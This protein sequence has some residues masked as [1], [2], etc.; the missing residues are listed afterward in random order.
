MPCF[1]S[2]VSRIPVATVAAPPTANAMA[3][4]E[5]AHGIVS[6]ANGPPLAHSPL[7]TLLPAVA[8]AVPAEEGRGE[9]ATGKGIPAPGEKEDSPQSK[10]K[11]GA[12]KTCVVCSVLWRGRRRVREAPRKDLSPLS[13]PDQAPPPA[14]KG[15]KEGRPDQRPANGSGPT[16]CVKRQ[17]W[18]TES[19]P[20]LLFSD[21][22]K[23]I[24]QEE[25]N[26]VME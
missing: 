2:D 26:I 15:S 12:G 25:R 19:D 8:A 23:S 20:G 24:D 1:F 13:F 3:T 11:S 7:G 6:L 21:L 16:A 18:R 5:R 10:A 9:G 17:T 4:D 22:N 14:S